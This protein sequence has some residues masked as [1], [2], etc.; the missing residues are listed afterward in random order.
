MLFYGSSNILGV[1]SDDT[2]I[3]NITSYREGLVR[4][5][6]LPPLD[7]RLYL[8]DCRE[9][10]LMYAQWIF[11]NDIQFFD[12]F[13]IIYDLYLGKDVF[14][15]MDTSDWSENIIESILKLIQQRYGYNGI[16]IDSFDSY[17]YCKNTIVSGF[18]PYMIQNLDIDKDRFSVL[19][20]KMNPR[21]LN[22]EGV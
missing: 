1:L 14:L 22:E 5:N 11:N 15:V 4:L 10:D 19:M 2:I 18:D 7:K 9:F 6:L 20:V 16:L 21:L 17:V 13:R 12:F 8:N 3:Y